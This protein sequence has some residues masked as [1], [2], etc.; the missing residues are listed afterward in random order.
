MHRGASTLTS[1]HHI[2]EVA[3]EGASDAS[4]EENKESVEEAQKT[5]DLAKSELEDDFPFLHSHSIMGMWGALEAMVEDLAIA[6]LEH[7]PST[8]SDPRFAKIRI[9]FVQFQ[10][11]DENQRLRYLVTELQRDLG[12][13]LKSGA[14]KFEPLLGALGLGGPV[15]PKVRDVIYEAQNLRNLFAHKGGVADDRFVT[16]CPH[17]QYSV[18]N[19]VKINY[20]QFTRIHDG[21]FMYSITILNRCLA[22]SGQGQITL[23][24]TGYEDI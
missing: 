8:L 21:L 13:G 16:N 10:S 18:G 1:F 15:H 12:L 9:P 3:L 6:W 22:A 20:Q 7:N 4:R 23:R 19:A 2:Y 14:T 11:L 5:A 17:L 24:M